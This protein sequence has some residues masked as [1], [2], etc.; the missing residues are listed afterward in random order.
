MFSVA[1]TDGGVQQWAWPKWDHNWDQ[2]APPPVDPNNNVAGGAVASRHLLLIRHGQYNLKGETDK[3]RYLTELGRSQ[4]A[5]TGTR[6]A[7]LSLPYTHILHSNMSRAVETADLIAEQLP[8]VTVLPS[9][10]IL[11]EGSPIKPEP[12]V[13]SWRPEAAYWTDGA[14]IEAAFRKHF[15]RA[16]AEQR[17]DSYE[18]VVCHAN[19]IRYFVCRALQLPPEAWLRISLKHA[20]V[21]WLTIRPDGR[22]SIR[23]LGEAGHLKPD[24]LTTS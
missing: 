9:D 18:V 19:V 4:A 14:R 24:M 20:S 8:S 21:T 3:E 23:S 17:E 12:P 13:G 7:E 15:H 16:E 2:R 22:V 1:E 10:A 6:L 11:R 5:A